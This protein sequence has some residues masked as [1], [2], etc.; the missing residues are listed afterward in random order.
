M[1]ITGGRGSAA[2][3]TRSPQGTR[4][5]ANSTV[6]ARPR[7]T[8]QRRESRGKDIG[9]REGTMKSGDAAG[10][11]AKCGRSSTAPV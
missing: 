4:S 2:A 7:R 10:I 8:K 3:C 5:D 9:E 6:R 11:A 1:K